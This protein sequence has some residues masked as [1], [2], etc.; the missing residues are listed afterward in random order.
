M[1]I[2]NRELP[3][4]TTLKGTFKKVAYTSTVE[5]DADGKRT[6]RLADGRSFTSPSA[7]GSAVMGGV[8]CN[9]WRFWTVEGDEPPVSETAKAPTP[10]GKKAPSP[11]AVRNIRKVPNQKGTPE[12]QVKYFCSSCMDGFLVD[13]GTEPNECPKGHPREQTD[14][15]APPE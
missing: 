5:V 4:G 8:A 13:A 15:L 6:Y 2:T 11:R 7:A 1:P 10:R 14:E 9:G 3:A 12:G